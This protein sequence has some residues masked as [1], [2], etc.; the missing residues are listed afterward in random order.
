MRRTREEALET[1]G[2]ILDAAERVFYEHGVARTTLAEVAAEAKVTRGAIYWH[3]ANK[4]DLFRAMH[5]RICL[6]QEKF[7]KV[8]AIL[9][10]EDSISALFDMTVEACHDF[11]TDEQIKRVYSILL[12]RCEYV[13]EMEDALVRQREADDRFKEI[14]VAVFE[15]ARRDGELLP[16]WE[17]RLAAQI[18]FCSVV[19]LI[20]EWL[21]LDGNFELMKAAEAMVR[22][23]SAGFFGMS[24]AK[25]L[26]SA[27]S[28]PLA[29]AR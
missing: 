19:G 1:R 3:F 11:E 20:S 8:S 14:I 29:N 24:C 4:L 13:G 21:R 27:G 28:Q 26:K 6:P 25:A 16:E 12:Y 9:S 15:K 2:A 5:E 17:P 18:Y 23:L 10:A 7:C 22:S